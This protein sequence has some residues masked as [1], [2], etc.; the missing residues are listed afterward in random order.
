[1]HPTLYLHGRFSIASTHDMQSE[2]GKAIACCWLPLFH[3]SGS[4]TFSSTLLC[5]LI[6]KEQGGN[7]SYLL[8]DIYTEENLRRYGLEARHIKALLFTKENGRIS[9]S[10]YQKLSNVSKRTVSN[11]LQ[12]LMNKKLRNKTGTTRRGVPIMSSKGA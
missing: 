11:D 12:L 6:T 2:N 10:E 1:M 7:R 8:K 3:D 5:S 9:N 4:R